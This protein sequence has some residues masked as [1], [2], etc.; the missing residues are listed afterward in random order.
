MYSGC[1]SRAS[2]GRSETR[3]LK[4]GCASRENGESKEAEEE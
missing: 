2:K 3:C 4:E 1:N